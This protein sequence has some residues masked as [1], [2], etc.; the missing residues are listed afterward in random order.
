M[1][2]PLR[3]LEP[4]GSARRQFFKVAVY[5]AYILGA[6]LLAEKTKTEHATYFS[7]VPMFCILLIA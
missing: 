3:D 7:Y 1:S 5:D 6:C 4:Q 2:L